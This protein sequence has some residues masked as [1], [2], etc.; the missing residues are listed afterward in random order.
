MTQNLQDRQTDRL[1]WSTFFGLK[2]IISHRLESKYIKSKALQ[3]KSSE[4]WHLENFAF[5]NGIFVQFYVFRHN[6]YSPNTIQLSKTRILCS[7]I[8]SFQVMFPVWE[9][10]FT[11]ICFYKEANKCTVVPQY[12]NIGYWG[13]FDNLTSRCLIMEV[14]CCSVITVLTITKQKIVWL[15]K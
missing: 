7:F 3:I 5:Q 2:I 11:S 13:K 15:L 8:F 4:F 10:E 9:L 6:K 1:L 14:Y 12:L